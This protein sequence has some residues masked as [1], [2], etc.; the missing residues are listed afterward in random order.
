METNPQT[1]VPAAL[2]WSTV[3]LNSFVCVMIGWMVIRT[4]PFAQ[5]PHAVFLAVLLFIN[6]LQIVIADPK[7][8][9]SMTIVYMIAFPIAILIGAKLAENRI[10]ANDESQATS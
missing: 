3:V 6:F 8:K 7:P 2:F 9:K 5:F 4:A 10:R 1:A